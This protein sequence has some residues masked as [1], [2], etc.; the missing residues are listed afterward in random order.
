MLILNSTYF[1]EVLSE[2]KEEE[3]GRMKVT[4]YVEKDHGRLFHSLI[5][6]FYNKSCLNTCG[7]VDL[8]KI[9]KLGGKYANDQFMKSVLNLIN[10]FELEF[11]NCTKAINILC[12]IKLEISENRMITDFLTKFIKFLAKFFYPLDCRQNL[13]QNYLSLDFFPLI[14]IL[15][16]NEIMFGSD[17]TLVIFAIS[18]LKYHELRQSEN[19][20]ERI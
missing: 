7:I 1:Q 10:T 11:S 3:E 6:S 12:S 16:S 5:H 14:S 2:L 9:L 17:Q 8:V 18:W 19:V 20:I 15:E 13:L 4:V